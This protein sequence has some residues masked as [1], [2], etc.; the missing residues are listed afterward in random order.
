MP[1]S[2][3][4]KDLS[5]LTVLITGANVGIGLETARMLCE[6][7]AQVTIACRNA[8]KAQA[9][10]DDI[11]KTTGNRPEIVSVDLS[12]L[13]SAAALANEYTAKHQRLDILINN[14]GVATTEKGQDGLTQDGFEIDFQVNH[15]AHFLLTIRLLPLIKH[16]AQNK[17][18]G[19]TPRVVVIGSEGARVGKVDY[20]YLQ[21]SDKLP[22]FFNRYANSKLMNAMFA[23][24]LA[25]KVKEDG[26]VAHVLHPGFV[27]SDIYSKPE[28]KTPKFL[29]A[30]IGFVIKATARNN[31]QGAMTSVHVA[32]SDE[33]ANTTG[34]YW[35]S[36]KITQFPNKLVAD[37]DCVN[38]LWSKSEQYLKEKGF[39]VTE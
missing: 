12:K 13:E 7:G 27:A 23:K 20:A 24:K 39:D 14:A 15:L 30:I 33:A 19:F 4:K 32:I 5:G 16:A 28:Y 8:Q 37:D 25:E 17:I 22:F 34:K 9:A 31:V 36:C 2:V 29:Q 18:N 3:E 6:M 21:D 1:L 10:A 11:E 38:E 26:I 35:D